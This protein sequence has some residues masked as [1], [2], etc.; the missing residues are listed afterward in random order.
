MNVNLKQLETFV[1]V[2][3]LGSFRRAASQLNT[4]QPNISSRISTLEG[5]LGTT[6]MERDA[7]SVRL[8]SRGSELLVYA[9]KVLR[10]M[11]AFV[12]AADNPGL[13]DGVLRLGVSEMV[14]STWL[15]EFMLAFKKKYPNILIELKVDLSVILEQELADH[16][17]DLAFQSGPF[18]RPSSGDLGLGS[19]PI[20]WVTSP[21]I[22]DRLPKKVAI[23]DLVQ[24][25]I[26]THARN[27]RPYA[28]LT[29][30]FSAQQ[31]LKVRLVPSS[32]LAACVQMA[33]DSF[34][35]AVL[36]LPLVEREIAEGKLAI[37]NY[38]WV[39]ERLS[40]HARYDIAKSSNV[41]ASAAQLA[42]DISNK[43]AQS[44]LS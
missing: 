33:M 21:E 34:G 42:H 20:V 1:W 36:L 43:F 18:T 30:H 41:V 29:E 19:F 6:L 44:Y 16:A 10:S 3:D 11:E 4:T 9:R 27:T 14:V 31:N 17:I 12:E 5:L 38:D 28:E 15:R 8:T 25:P 23:D 32:N 26:I 24:L 35:I 13:F 40:F 2:A 22:R 7:G 39:P 37:V